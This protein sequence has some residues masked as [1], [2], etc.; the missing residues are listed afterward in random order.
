MRFSLA[1][2][3]TVCNRVLAVL[4]M[5]LMGVVVARVLG[6]VGQGLVATLV[7]FVTIVLQFGNFGVYASNIRFV[8]EDR[9]LLGRAAGTSLVVGLLLGLVLFLGVVLV[10]IVFPSVLGDVPLFLLLFFAV[11]LPFS[12]LTMFFQGLLLAVDRIRSY[13]LLIFTR[14][15]LLFFGVVFLLYGLGAGVTEL[16]VFFVL[17][18]VVVCLMHLVRVYLLSSF[19]PSVDFE[20]IKRVFGY[21]VKVYLV[22]QLT[23]LVLKS[24]IILVNFFVGLREAGIYS[25]SAKIADL[26][27]M[28]PATVALIY[29][30]RASALGGGA[31]AFT[32][33]ILLVLSVFMLVFCG[34]I[35]FVAEPLTLLLF[36][37]AY[38]GSVYPLIVLLPG[39]FFMSLET[40]FMNYYA[41]KS[42]P[43]FAVAT[44]VLGL[45]LN[46][47]LNVLYLPV[48][49]IVAAAWS[50]TVC[51]TLMFII[52]AFY[53]YF[54][55]GVE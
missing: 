40:I 42:M 5:G 47:V 8:S 21:G 31:R 14:S 20:F 50:S 2:A 13:N 55:R 19:R 44:P 12:L 36:G 34:F 53:Y 33:R 35:F 15:V 7:A 18:E 29:F 6:P 54:R 52:L 26:I 22:T 24:D 25:V 1:S 48:Y 28:V 46:V 43:L 17:V 4:L 10:S 9:G 39:I 16:I 32:N 37:E 45:L 30:P 11:S 27:Y 41:S 3:L 38:S 51:Y 23:L 49:G